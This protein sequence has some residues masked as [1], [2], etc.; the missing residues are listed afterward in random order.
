MLPALYAAMGAA[1]ETERIA[2]GAAVTVKQ[3]LTVFMPARVETDADGHDWA[4]P[5]PTNGSGDFTALAGS[6]G[7]A[8]LPPGADPL[9]ITLAKPF[10]Q[11]DLAQ[12]VKAALEDPQKR[13]VV[14]FRMPKA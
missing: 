8:E 3:A 7:F 5:R 10:L 12:A 13:R 11:Y 6:H 1:A 9:L 2:L 14:R 4:L